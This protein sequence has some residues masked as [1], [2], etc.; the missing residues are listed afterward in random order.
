MS[1]AEKFNY[2]RD[3]LS[4]MFKQHT[5]TNLQEYIHLNKLAK[6]KELLTRT[7]QSV[8][9]IALAI[10][11]HDEKYF[12]RMFKAHEKVTPTEYRKA[13]YRTYLNNA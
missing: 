11:I 10:G 6:A 7:D 2:N 8:K 5:G 4:R 13:Y 9:D 3:Y 12:M 1:I